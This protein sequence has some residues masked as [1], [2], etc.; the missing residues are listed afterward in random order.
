MGRAL[1]IPVLLLSPLVADGQELD[2]GQLHLTLDGRRVGTER[3][4]VWRTGSTVNAV[5]RIE[6]VQ[7]A[8]WEVGLQTDAAFLPTQYEVHEGRA[9]LVS[10]QR[11]ADRVRFHFTSPEGERWKEYPLQDAGAILEPGVAHHYLLLVRALRDTAE[12]RLALL[13]PLVGRSVTARLAGRTEDTVAIGEGSVAATRY[14]VEIEGVLH[15]VWLDAD[16]RLLRVVDPVT[17][18]EAVRAPSEG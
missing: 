16:D 5:A 10:G 15:R 11:F 3:F 14:D 13:L 6:I 7:R 12:G 2:A 1:A 4:R 9:T 17:K 18:R 8:A